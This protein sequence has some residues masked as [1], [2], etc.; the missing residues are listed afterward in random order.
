MFS[1]ENIEEIVMESKLHWTETAM[2]DEPS[3][4]RNLRLERADLEYALIRLNGFMHSPEYEKV[5]S[6]KQRELLYTQRQ[7]MTQLYEILGQRICN[8]DV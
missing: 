8:M 2:V 1:T 6:K 4:Q 7:V 3:W 5:A